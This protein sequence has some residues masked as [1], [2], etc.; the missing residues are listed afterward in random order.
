MIELD[1]V[2]EPLCKIIN[3]CYEAIYPNLPKFPK[4]SFTRAMIT[5]WKTKVYAKIETNM[6][7]AFAQ[8][9]AEERQNKVQKGKQAIEL[10]KK[11]S[12]IK[13][14]KEEEYLQLTRNY[15][16]LSRQLNDI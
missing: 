13:I 11:Q 16:L 1:R 6:L 3:E 4:F 7:E 15:Q 14:E 5:F 9:L 12:E 8:I 2:L 10:K